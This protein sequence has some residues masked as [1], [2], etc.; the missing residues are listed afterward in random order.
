MPNWAN[1]VN[2]DWVSVMM[3]AWLVLIGLVGY[4]AI[5][6]SWRDPQGTAMTHVLV[7][8]CRVPVSELEELEARSVD[9]TLSI[10]GPAG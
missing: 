9:H 1:G 5:A 6:V 7:M 8:T 3:V 4:V 2:W 10:V